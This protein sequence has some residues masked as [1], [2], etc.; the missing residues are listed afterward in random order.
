MN[1]E[2]IRAAVLRAVQRVA[3]EADL[4]QLG[5]TEDI[6]DALD[7]DSMDFLKLVVQLHETLHVDVPERD[8]PKVRT[9]DAC[10]RYVE[11]KLAAQSLHGPAKA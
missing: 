7:I 4:S 5:E 1:H 10:V 9:I 3:P 8:Y 6:R 11:A 2:E